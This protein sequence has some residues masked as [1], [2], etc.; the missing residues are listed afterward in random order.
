M[1]RTYV[2][3][4]VIVAIAMICDLWFQVT[5][6]SSDFTESGA[7]NFFTFFLAIGALMGII[8]LIMGRNKNP[9][10]NPYPPS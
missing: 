1:K 3:A 8:A 2:L 5:P 10:N 4:A 9:P 6:I 7:R